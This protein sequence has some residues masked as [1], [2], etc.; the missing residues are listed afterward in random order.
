MRILMLVVALSV[1]APAQGAQA[2]PKLAA[3]AALQYW[4]AFALMP[5]VNEDEQLILQRWHTASLHGPARTLI[6]R[7]ANS[8]AALHRG[9][10]LPDCGWGPD[11]DAGVD[12]LLPHLSKS[13]MLTHL[14]A[15]HAR[16]E[17][18]HG[19]WRTGWQDVG[20][21]L[22]FARHASRNPDILL[23]SLVSYRIETVAL[24]TASL[25][26][27]E[28]K[29]V[30]PADALKKLPARPSISTMMRFEKE[31]GPQW[32]IRK[33]K[34]AERRQP[35]SWR[36]FW[37][38]LY[39]LSNKPA[40]KAQARAIQTVDQAIR[41]FEDAL[42]LDDQL[43]ALAKLPWQEF[44]TRYPAFFKKAQTEQPLGSILLPAMDRFLA[45]ERRNQAQRAMFEAAL[46]VLRDGRG[47]LQEIQDPFG[48]GPFEYRALD[49][50]FELRS[51]LQ[52]QGKPV[53]LTVG[54]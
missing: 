4:Q 39:E 18:A 48:A 46:T 12:M 53:T 44:D 51:R 47:M 45:A 1:L 42:P 11:Y 2:A 36:T 21:L 34:E 49:H 5:A 17:F 25:Y 13:M 52:Y 27:P 23:A 43:T 3:N 19:H 14:V 35:G 8:R 22:H 20:D 6:E 54:D 7:S 15:L 30:I 16:D 41:A 9:A 37:N 38:N 24:E 31:I 26:L 28:L 40:L 32:V 10:A 33:L 29:T 50:G